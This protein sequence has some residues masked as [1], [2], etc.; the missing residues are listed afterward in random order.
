MNQSQIG[1]FIKKSKRRE[2]L[3]SRAACREIKCQQ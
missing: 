3:N 2:K 1:K